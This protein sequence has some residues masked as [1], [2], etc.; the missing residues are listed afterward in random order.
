MDNIYTLYSLSRGLAAFFGFTVLLGVLWF[1]GSPG[2]G[3]HVVP[4]V[5]LGFGSIAA[6]FVP[7]R[8]L[9]NATTR[10]TLVTLCVVAIG[11][12]LVLIAGDLKA[13]RGIEWDVIAIRLVHI[14]AL[15]TLATKS[16]SGKLRKDL[17]R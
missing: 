17:G 10:R 15:A 4:N 9:S 3:T 7:Q 5:L 6:A 13:A 1:I 2:G 8:K 12:G 16:L 14:A 11:S